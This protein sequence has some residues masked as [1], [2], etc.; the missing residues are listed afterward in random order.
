[1]KR[2]CPHVEVVD[3]ANSNHHVTLDNPAGF[4]AAVRSFLER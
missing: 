2:R 1:V 4:V 3:V